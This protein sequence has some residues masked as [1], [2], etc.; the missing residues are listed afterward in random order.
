M[1]DAPAPHAL[2]VQVLPAVAALVHIL[3]AAVGGVA[4]VLKVGV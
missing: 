3:D 4:V 2:E 1:I